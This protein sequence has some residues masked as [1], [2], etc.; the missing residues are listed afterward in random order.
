ME[1]NITSVQFTKWDETKVGYLINFE[2]GFIQMIV[3]KPE[4]G[5]GAT[6]RYYWHER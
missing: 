1:S 2:G 5:V 3:E 6:A 4:S